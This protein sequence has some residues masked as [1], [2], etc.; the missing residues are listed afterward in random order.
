LPRYLTFSE[1]LAASLIVCELIER[2]AR[3]RHDLNGRT[4]GR[5]GTSRQQQPAHRHT[6]QT[7]ASRPEIPHLTPTY[8]IHR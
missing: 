5:L 7:G 8:L 2:L 1:L 3:P 6:G 4:Q